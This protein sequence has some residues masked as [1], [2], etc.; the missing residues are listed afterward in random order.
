MKIS[1]LSAFYPFRG[2]I[3]QFSANLYRALEKKHEVKAHTFKRQYPSFLFP[4]KTQYTTEEDKPDK[5]SATRLLDTINPWSYLRTSKAVNQNNP[6][7]FITNYWMT[8]FALAMGSVTKRVKKDVKKITILHNLIPHEKRFFDTIANRF[9]LKSNDGYVVMSDVVLKDLLSMKPDA[10][11]LRID[12][13]VYD[14]FGDK[15]DQTEAQTKLGI[16]SSKRTILFFGI[17]R[18]YKGL[19]LLLHAMNLLDESYQLVIA[20]EVYG[21]FDKY[22]QIITNS[23]AKKRVFV[24]DKYIGDSEVPTFFSAADVCILPYRTATQ[25]GITSIAFHFDLPL[26]AT[27][28]GGLKETIHHMKTGIIVNTPSVEEIATAIQQY[29]SQNNKAVFSEHIRNEKAKRSWDNFADEI[30]TFSE[31]L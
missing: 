28:V 27:D 20:G 24:F 18:D 21:S 30:L 4:G 9:F 1:I 12:H 16:D 2:G 5:I 11:Y 13:P 29:F 22:Q 8:F 26:I 7:I 10:N 19:D 6:E 31:S 17:I 25:S 3:A 15:L 14:H 23:S